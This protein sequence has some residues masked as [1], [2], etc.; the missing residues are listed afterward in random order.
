M[1]RHAD[2]VTPSASRLTTSLRDIGYDFPTAMADLI[3]NSVSADAEQIDIDFFYRGERSFITVAD[4]GHGMTESE[5][6]EA[7]RFGT[8]RDYPDDDLGRFG[9]GLKTASLSQARRL[10]VVSRHAPQRRWIR[11]RTLDLDHIKRV[12]RWQ[13]FEPSS[14][15]EG[16]EIAEGV[17]DDGPGTVIVLEKLDRMFEG[18]DA[19]S[20]WGERRLDKFA[21]D[22][23]EHL[24]MIF[25]RFLEGTAE[26][27]RIKI[28]ING[29][30]I[31]PWNPF[32]PREEATESLGVRPF[33]LSDDHGRTHRVTLRGYILPPRKRFS[34][35][36]AFE[37]LGGPR[38]WNRQQGL[39]IYRQDRLVQ[40]GGWSGLRSFD[41]HTKL[42]RAA[43]DFPRGLD[44]EFRI[45]VA[46]MRVS[47]PS[48]LKELISRPVN[49]LCAKADAVYRHASVD[50]NDGKRTERPPLPENAR[51]I[52]AAI[53][54]AALEAGHTD[55][56]LAIAGELR[57]RHPEIAD[58]LGL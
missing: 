24:A 44:H 8:R 40:A 54:V 52:G 32:A 16:V 22:L 47:I 29:Q 12:D 45:N 2:D 46:K 49:K 35:P 11:A 43:L 53:K 1:S 55:A 38:R 31:E 23:R 51:T 10:T 50:K 39:Y 56:L 15:R 21:D 58:G 19:S 6:V 17:L 37:R 5:I 18:I 26:G 41:E 33:S 48:E 7:L 25:H 14:Y 4:N 9:L 30:K 28:L 42:A 20:G 3:D 27:G 36:A 57:E 13:V 34:S